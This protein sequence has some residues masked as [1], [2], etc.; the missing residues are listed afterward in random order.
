MLHILQILIY[1][2]PALTLPWKLSSPLAWMLVALIL[3][4]VELATP[5]LFFFIAFAIGAA[6]TGLV[7]FT[8]I[9]LALQCVIFLTT[10]IAS[11]VILRKK[12]ASLRKKGPET[13][14]YALVNKRG[15]VTS[16]IHPL[17][18]GRVKVDREEW[19]AEVLSGS[20]L[21]SGTVV[22]IL[23]VRGNRLTVEAFHEA[24]TDTTSLSK[25]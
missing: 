5:G 14:I 10:A 3:L 8:E 7:S 4:F 1:K 20:A 15:V 9:S 19:P 17:R 23:R 24:T 18:S 21:Q 22:R 2:I 16:P 12:T 11:F 6:I 25:E 13:N